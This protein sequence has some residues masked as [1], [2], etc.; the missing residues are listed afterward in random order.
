MMIKLYLSKIFLFTKHINNMLWILPYLLDLDYH[1]YII[2][3]SNSK[4]INI[5][6]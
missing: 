4:D 1:K 5:I 3:W 2:Y 6:L